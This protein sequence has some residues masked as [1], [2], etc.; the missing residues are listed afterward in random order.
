MNDETTETPET[1]TPEQV[2]PPLSYKTYRL[3]LIL[4]VVAIVA[5]VAGG[6]AGR[7]PLTNLE[8]PA[9]DAV[10]SIEEKIGEL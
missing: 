3:A 8:S 1:A 6:A 9:S 10:S 4:L 7:G 2:A 5:A